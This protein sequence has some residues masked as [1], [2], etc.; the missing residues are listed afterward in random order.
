MRHEEL[1]ARIDQMENQLSAK[2]YSAISVEYT[3]RANAQIR[4]YICNSTYGAKFFY[5]DEALKEAEKYVQDLPSGQERLEATARKCLSE[6]ITACADAG[7][8]DLILG[9]LREVVKKLSSNIIAHK[10][11]EYDEIPF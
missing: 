1:Q 9:Q 10:K 7:M 5:G 6:A 8:S 4:I 11:E 2:G 3:I